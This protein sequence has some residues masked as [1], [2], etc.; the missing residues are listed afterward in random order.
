MIVAAVLATSAVPAHQEPQPPATQTPP[1][2]TGP[3]RA[4]W[5]K[6]DPSTS[7]NWSLNTFDLA[8]AKY[9]PLDQIN[10]ST[11]GSLAV[12]W[13]YHTRGSNATPIVVDGVMYISTQGGRQRSTR[14]PAI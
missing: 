2:P 11:V 9:V 13:L 10:A 14:Q 8:N 3:S 12:R 4:A 7:T 5:P 6:A 1:T